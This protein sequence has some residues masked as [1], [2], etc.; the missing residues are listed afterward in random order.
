[1]IIPLVVL[2]DDDTSLGVG[3]FP[4]HSGERLEIFFREPVEQGNG[5]EDVGW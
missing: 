4:G 1:M 5:A 3:T 2:E